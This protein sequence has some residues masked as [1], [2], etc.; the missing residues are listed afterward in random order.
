M[1]FMEGSIREPGLGMVEWWEPQQESESA[2][3]NITIQQNPIQESQ[4]NLNENIAKQVTP[5]I[6]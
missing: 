2:K 3:E 1:H 6:Q 4:I 5:S